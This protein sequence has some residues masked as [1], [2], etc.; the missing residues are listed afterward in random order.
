MDDMRRGRYR[1]RWTL[2]AIMLPG[3]AVSGITLAACRTEPKSE[4]ARP[5]PDASPAEDGAVTSQAP[6]AAT[7]AALCSPDPT[8]PSLL[9][10][11]EASAAAEVELRPGVREILVVADSE[12]KGAAMAYAL[13]DGPAR[14]LTLPLDPHVSDDVEGVSWRGKHLFVLVSSGYVE[15]FTPDGKGG[16]MRDGPAYPLGAPPFVETSTGMPGAP[17]DYEGLCLRAA[18]DAAHCAGYAASRAYGWLMCLVFNGEQLRVDP[19]HP[20]IALDL[21]KH[22]LSDCAFGAADGPARDVML[23]ATNIYGGSAVYRFDEDTHALL[24][25]DIPGTANNE[26]VAI[27]HQG[28]LYQIMDANT[29]HSPSARA[30]C[31]GW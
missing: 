2:A 8:F 18:G 24:P 16:L 5:T 3:V 10:I 6:D 28:R 1:M 15:R 29:D 23:V 22:A 12:N 25:L 11:P 20:R 13:P 7:V 4:P 21:K 30:T 26:A 17:P 14:R 9:D 19:V 31:T 27:D